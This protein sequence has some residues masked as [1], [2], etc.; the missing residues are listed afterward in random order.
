MLSGS[1]PNGWIYGGLALVTLTTLMFEILLTRI[2]SVTM[3]Y[4]FAF[5]AIS[6][7]MLGMTVGAIL[8]YLAPE[9][10]S[11]ERAPAEL[12]KSATTYS[13]SLV[14]AFLV[15][16]QI[17]FSGVKTWTGI[18]FL[19]L[20]FVV[21]AIPF[22]FSG[23]AV[24][25][26]LTKFRGFT[27]QLYAA[28]LIGAAAGCVLLVL[29]LEMTDAP[30]AVLVAG[31]LAALGGALLGAGARRV[32]LR[33]RA[34]AICALF[35]VAAVAH[36][37]LAAHGWHLL[38]IVDTA[39]GRTDR[40][41]YVRW[42]S[43]SRV[44]V[45]GDGAHP[46]T[47]AGW[48][49]SEKTGAANAQI[50][51]R[52]MGIDTWAATVITEFNGDTAP[53]Q[54]LKDDVTNIAHY[55]RRDA[56][57]LVVGVGGGRDVLS[58]LVFDQKSVTGVE[59]N[60]N[61]LDASTKV[62]GD[63]AGRLDRNPKVNLVVDE[64]RSY[65]VRSPA[66]YDILQISLIDTWAATAAGAFVLTENSLYTVEAWTSFLQHLN[67]RGV[68]TVSRWYYPSR[69]G[70]ALRITSLAR[71]ALDRI[72]VADPARHVVLV[73]TSRANGLA[74][75]FGNGVATILVSRDPF[76][77]AD[78]D[79][80]E[81]EV[82][83]LG[84]DIVFSPRVAGS[85]PGFAVILNRASANQFYA[86]YPLDVSPP[87]D[88]RPFF[89][90]MLR[91]RDV[92][93]SLDAN[94][95]DPNRNNLEAVRLLMV[96]VGIVT[97][98]TVLCVVVPL[99]LSGR[100][101]SNLRG[102]GQRGTVQYFTYFMAIGLGFMFVEISQMQRLMVFLGHPTYALSVVLL[103]LLVGSGLGSFA[104]G[105]LH[106]GSRWSH[107]QRAVPITIGV[108]ALFGTLTPVLVREMAGASTFVRIAAAA[109]ILLCIGLFMGTPFPLGMKQAASERPELTPWLWGINGAAS[110]L[111]SVLA[112]V[113]SLTQGISV[114][115]WLGVACYGGAWLACA[116]AL[117][118]P[119]R[120]DIPAA[121]AALPPLD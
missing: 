99:V 61:V 49:L 30:S 60:R 50:R 8:V 112:T 106:D 25:I 52:Y 57:V 22:V 17:P 40:Y 13:V 14:A 118:A 109:F 64:A 116:L 21:I 104:V 4:H 3:W 31:A 83:R 78:L 59:I 119:T 92:L 54:Y 108:L 37:A 53:L 20:S 32:G 114:A 86:S 110:V 90:Q 9:R 28:D 120:V 18:A 65:V 94:F 36:S 68:L 111:C 38:Q 69:P 93:R 2:F 79:T 7:A 84:F 63:F 15:Y 1:R 26:A 45:G 35:A 58:A 10:Y 96:L 88:D 91:A 43:H 89:F 117:R 97:I 72:G 16:L 55:L 100:A 39:G 121:E 27:S 73:K 105:R 74:G 70:E 47:A 85:D 95:F 33:R 80:L 56:D 81:R 42:N 66:R 12:A 19:A 5:M 107:P 44:T 115:F 48:G 76:S 23:V 77:D 103:T 101:R 11:E 41:P 46:S 87:T 62:F 6:L 29:T 71:A 34:S 24:S 113:V 67:P 51:Q 98:L 102:S 82:D 75:A